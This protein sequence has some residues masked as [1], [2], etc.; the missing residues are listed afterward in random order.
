MEMTLAEAATA[1]K[2]TKQGLLTA[3]NKGRLSATKDANGRWKIDSAELFRVYPAAKR[4]TPSID[5]GLM[6][7]GAEL[8]TEVAVLR[9]KLDSAEAR[10]AELRRDLE[11]ANERVDI[12]L[13]SLPAGVP[14]NRPVEASEPEKRPVAHAEAKA[15]LKRPFWRR[16]LG[17][18]HDE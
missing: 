9:A 17:G 4:E 14:S 7:G 11:A 10:A 5:D 15:G 8:V 2:M 12:L 1:V 13:R 6:A 3:I 16:W 18:G